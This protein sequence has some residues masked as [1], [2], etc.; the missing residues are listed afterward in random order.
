MRP[1]FVRQGEYLA[2]IAHRVG[3]DAGAIWEHPRNETLR[4]QRTDREVLAPGDVLYVPEPTPTEQ[5]ISSGGQHRYRG[6]VPQVTV[7]VI[8]Q[9]GAEGLANE[10]YEILGLG[11]P[12]D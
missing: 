10:P 9:L 1:H 2:R 5:P 11:P 4:S 12:R 3:V 8:L 6:R 7:D